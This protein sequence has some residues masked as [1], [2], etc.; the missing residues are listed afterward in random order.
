MSPSPAQHLDLRAVSGHTLHPLPRP[1]PRQLGESR[2]CVTARGSNPKAEKPRRG[3]IPGNNRVPAGP[4][5]PPATRYGLCPQLPRSSQRRRPVRPD[6]QPPSPQIPAAPRLPISAPRDQAGAPPAALRAP[7]TLGLRALHTG[8]QTRTL[9]SLAP[10]RTP[11]PPG[12]C[13]AP[14]ASLEAAPYPP[15]R[16][17]A[18]PASGCP[19]SL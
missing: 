13:P 12:G 19:G 7:A 4:R 17:T 11:A 8:A 14:P 6:L 1:Q 10:A 3:G 15:A 2:G 16:P 18:D 9:P 5:S